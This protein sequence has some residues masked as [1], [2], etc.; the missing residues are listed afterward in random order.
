MVCRHPEMRL[1]WQRDVTTSL[2]YQ[3]KRLECV[4]KWWRVKL[5]LLEFGQKT[6]VIVF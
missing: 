1:P 2:L 3:E 4:I 6:S 5:K